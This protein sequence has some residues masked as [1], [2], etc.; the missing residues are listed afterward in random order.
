MVN[1]GALILT[2]KQPAL[3]WINRNDPYEEG[4]KMTLEMINEDRTIYLVS[5][6]EAEEIDLWIEEN[7]LDLL[8]YELS[9]HYP[10]DDLRPEGFTLEDFRLWFDYDVHSVVLDTVGDGNLVEDEEI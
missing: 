3:D 1:R 8:E 4:G 7:Y 6:E 10:D 2:Y 5:D 9:G